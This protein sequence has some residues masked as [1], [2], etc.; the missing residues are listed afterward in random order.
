MSLSKCKVSTPQTLSVTLYDTPA[1]VCRASTL[2]LCSVASLES[3][4]LPWQ[5]EKGLSPGRLDKDHTVAFPAPSWD[6]CV[7]YN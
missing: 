3:S 4:L 2:W 5:W 6:F 1:P 7:Y